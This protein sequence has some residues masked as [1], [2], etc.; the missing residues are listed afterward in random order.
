MGETMKLPNCRQVS[1]A[2]ARGDFAR[3]PLGTRLRILAHLSICRACRRFRRQLQLIRM[4]LRH[5]AP[6]SPRPER[7]LEL[8]RAILARLN[9][10]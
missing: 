2:V 5:G 10:P 9:A 3:A 7:L 4:A 1:E 8:E 6:Q